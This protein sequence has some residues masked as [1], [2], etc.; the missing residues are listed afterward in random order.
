MPD[1]TTLCAWVKTCLPSNV[2]APKGLV[3]TPIAGDA[4][5]RTY[6]RLNTSPSL[7]AVI[8]PPEHENNP[9][10][11]QIDLFLR[12][13]G[14]HV[15]EIHAVDFL[16]GFLLLEDLGDGLLLPRL[17][18]A[19]M[20]QLYD[21]AERVLAM[22]QA[23]PPDEAVFPGYD[24]QRLEQE[25]ALFP[26]WFVE[27]LLDHRLAA[28]ERQMIES[29]CQRLAD[30]ALMQP[31]VVVHRDF[32]SR[33]LLWIA[34]DDLGV[35]DFQDAVVGPFTYDLV[36]LLKDCYIRWPA[37][38]VRERALM[39]LRRSYGRLCADSAL[40]MDGQLLAGST[41][42]ACSVTSRCWAFLPGCHCGMASIDTC[43][44]CRWY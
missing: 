11:V 4:G 37:E 44:I 30:S 5:F 26:E 3:A 12:K 41:G 7:V 22:M 24:R 40:P 32:H 8:A 21:L 15:P 35:V 36:S 13:S 6:Y 17:N 25:M 20:P 27:G 38:Q 42:W 29:M 34:D 14:V 19:S 2:T 43:R 18:S 16:Q 1:L 33:N 23:A 9:G 31:Q 10:F 28:D 39:F